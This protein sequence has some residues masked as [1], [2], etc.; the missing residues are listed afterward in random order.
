MRLV[1]HL[2]CLAA[3]KRAVIR[4]EPLSFTEEDGHRDLSH[5]PGEYSRSCDITSKVPQTQQFTTVSLQN[6]EQYDCGKYESKHSMQRFN[7]VRAGR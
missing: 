7:V 4:G 2:W 3:E 6:P 5:I 1:F